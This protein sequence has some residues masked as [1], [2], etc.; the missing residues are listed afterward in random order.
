MNYHPDAAT[1]AAREQMDIRA[2][3]WR[4]IRRALDSGYSME[5]G[6]GGNRIRPSEHR[7]TFDPPP[8][9]CSAPGR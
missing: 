3:Y 2:G 4:F 9:R 8:C 7:V 1:I 6:L 5:D